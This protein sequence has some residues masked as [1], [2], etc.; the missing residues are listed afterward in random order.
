M[1]DARLAQMLDHFTQYVGSSPYGSP[2]VL[3]AIAHMQAARGRLVSDGRHPRRGRGAGEARGRARRELRPGDGRRRPRHRERRRHGRRARP[4]ASACRATRVVSNMDAIRTYRELVGG[5]VG[6]RYATQG[7]RAR[8]LRRRA[9]SRPQPAL[10]APRSTTTSSS[11]AIPRRSSTASTAGASRRPIRPA[12][13]PR[14]PSPTRA[15]RRRAARRSTCSSTRR[16][17]ART[18]TGRGCSRPTAGPSSTS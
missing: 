3:C 5:E 10:R 8:L 6:E 15:S 17:C 2:A 11:R 18:T 14:P 12:I 13:S 9:L 16:I 7:L 4:A 1:K